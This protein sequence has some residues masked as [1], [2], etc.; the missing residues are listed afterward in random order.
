MALMY[1]ALEI[2]DTTATA[3]ENLMSQ[4]DARN[5]QEF[6]IAAIPMLQNVM[7]EKGDIRQR[8]GPWQSTQ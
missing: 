6:I 5:M 1:F 4:M 3:L 7:Q 8:A 2:D